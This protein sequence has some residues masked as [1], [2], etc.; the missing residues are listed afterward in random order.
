MN[1]QLSTVPGSATEKQADFIESLLSDKDLL[2]SPKFFDAVNAMDQEEYHAYIRRIAADVRERYSK[3]Q[4]SRMITA[5]TALPKKNNRPT[6]TPGTKPSEWTDNSPEPDAG[7]YRRPNGD[8]MRVYLGQQSGKMLAK[9]LVDTGQ[10]HPEDSSIHLHD[11]EYLGKATRF[12]SGAERMT[13]EE[14]K[15][16]GRMTG[17]CCRCGRRLDVPESV[18][19]GIGPV[20]GKMKHWAS[21]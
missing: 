12:M 2:A 15:E 9:K 18:E 14:A 13:L 21:A 5:L 8:I 4:A 3:E 11:W 16:Y 10:P 17:S 19:A 1:Y 6:S 7:M 20:C